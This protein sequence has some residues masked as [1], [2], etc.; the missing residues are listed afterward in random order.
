MGPNSNTK[1]PETHNLDAQTSS[2]CF[3]KKRR[4]Y[5][6]VNMPLS[7]HFWAL[8]QASNWKFLSLN[9]CYVIYVL[10][11]IKYWLMWFEI[12]LVFILFKYKK[13]RPNISGIRVVYIIQWGKKVFSQPPIVQVLP[14]KKMREACNF[15]HRYTS[16]MR[17]KIRKKKSRK[18]HCRIFKEFICK[19][20]WKISIWSPTNKQD[21]WLSQTCNFF[22]RLLCPPLVTCINGICLNSLSV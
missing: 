12:I 7:Q 9:I 11:W 10:L 6:I 1:T 14:L 19:L 16:T 13:K 4:C 17:N 20:W 22:K 18:S 5:T 2:N 21:C 15:H 8:E 3:E